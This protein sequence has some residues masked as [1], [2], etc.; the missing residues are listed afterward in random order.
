MKDYFRIGDKIYEPVNHGKETDLSQMVL[1]HQIKD[2]YLFKDK[3]RWR[4]G[5]ILKS[6]PE[7]GKIQFSL[8]NDVEQD[9][10]GWGETEEEAY[11]E[12]IRCQKS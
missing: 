9:L 4:V 7:K 10:L 1:E 12:A 11:K 8:T 2:I 3:D 6:H 5:V